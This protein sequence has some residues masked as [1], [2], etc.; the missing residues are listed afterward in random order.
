MSTRTLNVLLGILSRREIDRASRLRLGAMPVTHY[1][2]KGDIY[3]TPTDSIERLQQVMK[4]VP[5]PWAP[6]SGGSSP[7]CGP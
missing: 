7:K 4:I 6:T 3:V 1:M 5:E 2:T